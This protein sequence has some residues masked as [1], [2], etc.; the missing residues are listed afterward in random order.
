MTYKVI[1]GFDQCRYKRDGKGLIGITYLIDRN[2]ENLGQM[3]VAYLPSNV[4]KLKMASHSGIM[5]PSSNFMHALEV[6]A[7]Y[8]QYPLKEIVEAL[9][10]SLNHFR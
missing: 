3:R 8:L 6:N 2:F 7:I 9:N 5:I 1:K 10:I 4:Y